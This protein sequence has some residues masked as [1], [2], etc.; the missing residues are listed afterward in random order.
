M[1]V[2]HGRPEIGVTEQ[3]LDGADVDAVLEQVG[4]ESVSEGVAGSAPMNAG[5]IQARRMA[6]WRT[7]GCR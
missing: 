2:D 7:V 6:R 3:L 5:A 4:G 1:G